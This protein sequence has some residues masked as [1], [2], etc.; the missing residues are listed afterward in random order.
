MKLLTLLVLMS[1][2]LSVFSMSFR[3]RLREHY[4]DH[5]ITSGGQ[6]YSYKGLSNTFNFWY[7]KPFDF[8][9][10]LAI[11]P[12]LGNGKHKGGTLSTFGEEIKLFGAGIEGKHFPI[13]AIPQLFYRAGVYYTELQ[14][15]QAIG[16]QTGFSVLGA[17][18]YEFKVWKMGI[19]PEFAIR[20]SF[21]QNSTTVTTMGP[22]IGFHFYVM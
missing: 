18:G 6:E 22:A 13:K 8:A 3:P 16:D 2:S 9:L 17:I 20:K 5:T 4:D 7:E 14:T 11:T 12:V 1:M 21:L 15:D 19:A 10:G